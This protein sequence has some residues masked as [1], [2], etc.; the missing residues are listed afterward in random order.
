MH[1][2][3][4]LKT[5]EDFAVFLLN[6]DTN[7]KEVSVFFTSEEARYGLL[8]YD[9]GRLM[10]FKI[11]LNSGTTVGVNL[12]KRV[13]KKLPSCGNCKQYP[14]NQSF[15]KCMLEKQVECYRLG[16]QTCQ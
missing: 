13:W 4:I 6:I 9:L 1:S 5:I 3:L 2:S 11:S 16:N 10:P 8:V 12:K 14:K 7:L 15:M